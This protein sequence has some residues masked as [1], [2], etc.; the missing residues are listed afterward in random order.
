MR[1]LARGVGG[2][3]LFAPLLLWAP[4]PGA[5]ITGTLVGIPTRPPGWSYNPSSWYQRAPRI[6]VPRGQSHEHYGTADRF[7]R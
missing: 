4:T 1:W 6:P 7:A 3:V 2:W 5:L